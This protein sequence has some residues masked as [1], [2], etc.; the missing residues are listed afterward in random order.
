MDISIIILC[1]LVIVAFIFAFQ[2]GGWK[3][4]IA[5]LKQAGS[6]FLSVWWRL[7]LGII[8]GGL[9]QVLIPKS[10]IA[11]WLGP[12]SGFTGILIGSFVGIVV[13]GGAYVIIPIIASIY[14]AG[15]GAGPIIALLTAANLVRLHG[16][17]VLQIPFFG[18]RIAITRYVICLLIPPIVGLA[19]NEIFKL[20]V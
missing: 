11:D 16:L 8:L 4:P 17:F 1:I 3:L 7:L 5:G 2:R 13:T 19:G 6:I 18:F 9:I 20:L 14:A 15:A 12:S 10:L